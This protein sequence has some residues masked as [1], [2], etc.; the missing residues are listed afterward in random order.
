MKE[1]LKKVIGILPSEYHGILSTIYEWFESDKDMQTLLDVENQNK[2]DLNYF[3]LAIMGMDSIRENITRELVFSIACEL[4]NRKMGEFSSSIK[5][6]VSEIY[7]KEFD[8]YVCAKSE[9]ICDCGDCSKEYDIEWTRIE[10]LKDLNTFI[11]GYDVNEVGY[12]VDCLK[13]YN[14]FTT[15]TKSKMPCYLF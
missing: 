6:F 9:H 10:S 7:N 15:G 13:S 1:K 8:V 3:I 5:E 12:L 11:Q 4:S 14:L 2:R